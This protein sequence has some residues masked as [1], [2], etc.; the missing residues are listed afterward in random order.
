MNKKIDYFIEILLKS[1]K[2]KK[3]KKIYYRPSK[4]KN[5]IGFLF[6]SLIMLIL[7][8]I[9]GLQLNLL[10]FILFVGDALVIM[11][12]GVNLFTKRGL[13]LP[14]YVNSEEKDDRYRNVR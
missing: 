4:I 13:L 10:Y 7:L 8:F 2:E 1:H 11:Y 6:S 14:K 12:Y 5:I 3:Y 9:L